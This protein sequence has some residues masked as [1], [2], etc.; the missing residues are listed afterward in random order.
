MVKILAGCFVLSILLWPACRDQQSKDISLALSDSFPV[1]LQ[2]EHDQL[3]ARFE[4]IISNRITNDSV[5]TQLKEVLTHHF[6]EEEIY[7]WP[8]L[9]QLTNTDNL[10]VSKHDELIRAGEKLQEQLVHFDAEHQFIKALLNEWQDGSDTV[11]NLFVQDLHQH[12]LIEEEIYYPAALM[13][14]KYLR[15]KNDKP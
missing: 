9:T 11:I 2:N 6:R 10:Q 4:K 5:S 7:V 15:I 8:L 13:V 12:A 14:G 1:S 3:L